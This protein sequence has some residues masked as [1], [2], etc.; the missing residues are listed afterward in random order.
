LV[1][2]GLWSRPLEIGRSGRRQGLPP[3]LQRPA[4]GVRRVAIDLVLESF[5]PE[6]DFIRDTNVPTVGD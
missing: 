1:Q 2:E 3:S 4:R 6:L 5:R